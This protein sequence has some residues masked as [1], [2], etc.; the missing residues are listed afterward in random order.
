M[1]R[2]THGE[3]EALLKCLK[4]EIH[5][6]NILLSNCDFSDDEDLKHWNYVSDYNKKLKSAKQK[7]KKYLK[8]KE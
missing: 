2:L 7:L 3:I 6:T 5:T 8:E 1:S 4:I